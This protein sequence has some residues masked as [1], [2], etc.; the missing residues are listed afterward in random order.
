MTVGGPGKGLVGTLATVTREE[1]GSGEGY[2]V[3]LSEARGLIHADLTVEGRCQ[4][5]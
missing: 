4:C 1:S 3:T 5:C 2:D